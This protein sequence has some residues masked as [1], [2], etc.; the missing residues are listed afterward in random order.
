MTNSGEKTQLRMSR[1]KRWLAMNASKL[2]ADGTFKDT[3]VKELESYGYSP[4][5]IETHFQKFQ[6]EYDRLKHLDE[7][8]PEP[9]LIYTAW[10]VLFTESEK[11]QFNPDGSLKPEYVQESLRLGISINYLMSEEEKKKREV[12]S[13]NVRSAKEAEHGRNFGAYL[14]SSRRTAVREYNQT[15]KMQ[16]QDRRNGEEISSL[17][18]DVDPDEYYGG[19]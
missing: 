16:Q 9:W 7:T 11:K 10:D 6:A 13:Y 15:R 3:F 2:N 12:E 14:M 19:F 8:D 18:M 1:L 17:P 4:D 5:H